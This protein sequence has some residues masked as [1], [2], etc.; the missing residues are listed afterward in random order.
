MPRGVPVGGPMFQQ[1]NFPGQPYMMPPPQ[2]YMPRGPRGAPAGGVPGMNRGIPQPRPMYGMPPNMA[3]P[4]AAGPGPQGPGPRG[5]IKFTPQARNQLPGAP[6]AP[7]AAV[8]VAAAPAAAAGAA[9]AP[10]AAAPAGPAAVP[11]QKLD[12]SQ[13]LL[14]TADPGVQKNMIGERLY[15]LIYS[16]QPEL[17][18]KITGMLLEMDNAELINLIES[19]EALTSKIDEALVVLRAHTSE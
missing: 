12:F 17:A 2:G 9:A 15:P 11:G 16:S 8:P 14:A 6:V 4:Y 3:A 19:P 13:A 1:R 7:V 18:G 5:N 10:V